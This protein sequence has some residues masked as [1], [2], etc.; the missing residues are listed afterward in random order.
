MR[1]FLICCI[2]LF[3]VFWSDAAQAK[4]KPW[5]VT[6]ATVGGALVGQALGGY[7][8]AHL[9]GMTNPY[10]SDDGFGIYMQAVAFG[11]PAGGALLGS[12]GA[13]AGHHLAGG[14]RTGQVALATGVTGG[15]SAGLLMVSPV[16]GPAFV[17]TWG[18][19]FTGAVVGVPVAAGVASQAP[20]RKRVQLAVAPAVTPKYKGFALSA[21]F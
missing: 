6:T 11:A 10:G 16:T 20:K 17:P 7:A 3:S 21:R 19:G 2:A 18:A 9:V 1:P 12:A 15:V 4:P 5:V 14:E 13:V 8:G